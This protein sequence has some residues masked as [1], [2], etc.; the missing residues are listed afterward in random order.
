VRT[1]FSTLLLLR[2]TPPLSP[3][4]SLYRVAVPMAHKAK[5]IAPS[6]SSPNVN[7]KPSLPAPVAQPTSSPQTSPREI[8]HETRSQNAQVLSVIQLGGSQVQWTAVVPVMAQ[9]L[10]A[11]AS[12]KSKK[13]HRSV[14]APWKLFDHECPSRHTPSPAT[15][16]SKSKS[17]RCVGSKI[18]ARQQ[19]PSDTRKTPDLAPVTLRSGPRTL[20][21]SRSIYKKLISD[22]QLWNRRPPPVS[23]LHSPGLDRCRAGSPCVVCKRCS[24]RQSC[25]GGGNCR[26]DNNFTHTPPPLPPSHPPPSFPLPPPDAEAVAKQHN[27]ELF[28][29]T[30]SSHVL[31][32]P[33]T[34]HPL[35]LPNCSI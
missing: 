1:F 24:R 30:S 33:R 18:L 34:P 13:E 28:I 27:T 23:P 16:P 22:F 15:S 14:N 35:S 31:K 6:A 4:P 11:G 12:L 20:I 29:G 2:N 3:L 5:R 8:L 21:R 19:P 10:H 9:P 7:A 26:S 32:I 25:R 17:Q